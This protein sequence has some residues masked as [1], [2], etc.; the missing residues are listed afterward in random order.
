MFGG[1]FRT[2][3]SLSPFW[4][5]NGGRELA[6]WLWREP[7][8]LQS[9]TVCFWEFFVFSTV[10][11]FYFFSVYFF[12]FFLTKSLSWS[13]ADGRSTACNIPRVLFQRTA[14]LPASLPL[15]PRWPPT[16]DKLL[17]SQKKTRN[18]HIPTKSDQKMIKIENQQPNKKTKTEKKRKAKK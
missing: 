14:S 6:A 2:S 9:F 15:T 11:L 16:C 5:R 3:L 17:H 10:I 18:F 13:A 1:T 4:S 7:C 8:D 12:F